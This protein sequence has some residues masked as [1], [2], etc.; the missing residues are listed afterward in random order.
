MTQE[1]TNNFEE[2][3][4]VASPKHDIRARHGALYFSRERLLAKQEKVISEWKPG[5]EM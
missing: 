3:Q 5:T 1:I 2:R 4:E